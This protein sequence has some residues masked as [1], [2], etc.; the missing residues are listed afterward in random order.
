MQVQHIWVAALPD[1]STADKPFAVRASPML[2]QLSDD[3]LCLSISIGDAV[4]IV[5]QAQLSPESSKTGNKLLGDVQ[6]MQKPVAGA[7]PEVQSCWQS[8]AFLLNPCCYGLGH[9]MCVRARQ[10]LLEAG[11]LSCIVNAWSIRHCTVIL[12]VHLDNAS[13]CGPCSTVQ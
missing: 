8:C 2:V 12:S 6:V 1:G 7:Q 3:D 4:D 13:R 9:T 11:P 10:P 5:G